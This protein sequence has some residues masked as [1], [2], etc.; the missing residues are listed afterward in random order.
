[1]AAAAMEGLQ[2]RQPHVLVASNDAAASA[3]RRGGP[4]SDGRLNQRIT[5]VCRPLKCWM[6]RGNRILPE[7]FL[8]ED[9]LAHSNTHIAMR[10]LTTY[11][12]Q[13][14]SADSTVKVV[15]WRELWKKLA[16]QSLLR[17]K[18]TKND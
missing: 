10:I 16:S 18:S 3:A 12:A 13:S 7:S 5:S 17:T 14:T 9:L 2:R 6:R 11:P 1:M 15:Q 8:L 4:V